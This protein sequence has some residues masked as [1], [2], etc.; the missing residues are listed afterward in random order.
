LGV[1]LVGGRDISQPDDVGNLKNADCILVLG[2]QVKADGSPS[3]M[4]QDRLERAIA[5]YNNQGIRTKLLM[6]GDH[7]QDSYNEVATMR[8]YALDRG[9]PSEDIFMDHAGFSTYE[10]LYRAKYIFGAQ[11]VIIVTQKYHLYRA[12][13]AAQALGIEAYGVASD[14]RTY[15]GQ[16]ARDV[17]EVLARVKDFVMCIFKPEP[18]YLGKAIPISGSGELTHDANSNFY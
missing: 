15:S 1:L 9:V 2:C 10:S 11:K 8:Q 16:A 17:R 3:H 18:T 14:Y 6:S 13:Y 5:L 12:L 7:G 4:L